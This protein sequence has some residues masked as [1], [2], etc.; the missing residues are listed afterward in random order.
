MVALFRPRRIADVRLRIALNASIFDGRPSGLGAYTRELARA[1][2]VLDDELI[3]FTSRP[4]ALP[5][6]RAMLPLG[7]P[8]R[9]LPAH[10]W[11][12]LWSQMALPVRAARARAQVLLNT[13]PEGPLWFSI[14]QVT[15]VH[16]VLPLFFPAELPRQ[17]WYFRRLVPAVLRRARVVVADSGQTRQDVLH[18]YGLDP[19]LVTVVLPGVDHARF[20]PAAAGAAPPLGLNRYLLCV[21]NLLPHKNLP[22]LLAA[23]SRVQSDVQLVIAGYRDLRY[24][25]DLIRRARALRIEQRVTFLDFVPDDTLPALYAGACGVIVPSLYEGFGLPVVEAMACGA[26]VVA[27]TTAGLREAVGDAALLVDPQDEEAI[28]KALQRVIDDADLRRHLRARGLT[29]AARFT[30][31][32]TACG[33]RAAIERALSTSR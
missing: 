18:H 30:W 9:G 11:R 14:P 27:S 23:F 15:V 6:A 8:S 10:V 16:D 13:V 32:A 1:W 7:E 22:R 24:W 17:Q 4:R 28:V 29:H 3:V 31:E 25:P 19:E 21:G 33:V 12:L 2:R 26:P 20:R 5:G